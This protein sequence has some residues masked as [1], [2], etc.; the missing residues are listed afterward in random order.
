MAKPKF[1]LTAIPTFKAKVAIPVPG[2]KSVDVEFVYKHRT[3]DEYKEFVDNLPDREDVD[4]IM[5][6]ASGWDLEDAFSAEA[7]EAMTQN[8]IGSAYAIIQTYI[9]E[10]TNARVKN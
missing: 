4:V 5:D 7:M 9:S 1:N 3:R 10:L 8:Y 2:G 6:I